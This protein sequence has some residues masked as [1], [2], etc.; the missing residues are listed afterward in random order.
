MNWNKIVYDVLRTSPSVTALV[1]ASSIMS[2]GGL[3]GVPRERPFIVLG[4]GEE[5]PAGVSRS[6]VEGN[7]EVRVHDDPGDYQRIGLILSAVR[8][9]LVNYMES[10]LIAFLWQSDGGE[11][12]DDGLNTITRIGSF[13]MLGRVS[14]EV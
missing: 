12:P 3:K 1:P 11:L 6:V 4:F 9:A 13:R 5:T 2:A 8:Q 10:G 14:E 7:L